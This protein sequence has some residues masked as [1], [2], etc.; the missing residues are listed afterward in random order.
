MEHANLTFK[1]QMEA[2]FG[3]DKALGVTFRLDGK[4]GP[5]DVVSL[6]VFQKMLDDLGDDCPGAESLLPHGGSACCCTDYATHIYLA[7]PG[8][9]QIFGFANEDNPMSRVARERIHPGGHD[10]AVVDSRY[11]VDPWPRLVPGVLDQM[12]F[13]F[14]DPAD[15]A[16]LLDVYGPRHCWKHMTVAEEFAEA[17]RVPA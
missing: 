12:T 17:A 9:V 13:D 14:Q 7:L 8:R 6:E 2:Q 15:A 16:L 3:S 4:D 11:L 10:F 1:E 5:G